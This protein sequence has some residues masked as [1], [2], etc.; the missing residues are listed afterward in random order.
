M[1]EAIVPELTK[2]KLEDQVCFSFYSASMAINKIYKPIL[3]DAGLTYPQYLVMSVLWERDALNN[4]VIAKYLGL[5]ASTISPIV[6]RLSQM[7]FITRI[8]DE[9]NERKV[10]VKLTEQG[11][12]LKEQV[13]CLPYSLLEASGLSV[14]EIVALNK[15]VKKLRDS[16]LQ[17]HG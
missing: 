16:L 13:N 4:G 14:D 17:H 3:D 11:K 2:L 7:E 10:I 5:E 8:R 1:L 6:K 15:T 12:E 9:H